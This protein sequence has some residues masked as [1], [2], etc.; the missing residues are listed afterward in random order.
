[1]NPEPRT[2]T[3]LLG[4]PCTCICTAPANVK[5]T[6]ASPARRAAAPADP[7]VVPP[8]PRAVSAERHQTSAAAEPDVGKAGSHREKPIFLIVSYD[9]DFG[10]YIPV[11]MKSF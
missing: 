5:S 8:A 3:V 10:W 4:R 9:P 2:P 11:S 7:R 6:N 1:M